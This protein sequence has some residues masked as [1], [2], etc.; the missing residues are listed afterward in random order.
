[1]LPG[2][3]TLQSGRTRSKAAA[4]ARHQVTAAARHGEGRVADPLHEREYQGVRAFIFSCT[5]ALSPARQKAGRGP[6][7]RELPDRRWVAKG[8]SWA[9]QQAAAPRTPVRPRRSRAALRA[10]RLLAAPSASGHHGGG[11][12]PA[13]HVNVM[14]GMHA[15]QQCPLTRLREQVP[16]A[17]ARRSLQVD[18]PS[19][20]ARQ[21]SCQARLQRQRRVRQGA[22]C[23]GSRCQVRSQLA[24]G[25]GQG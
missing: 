19:H 22:S 15:H 14:C 12:S 24:L 11:S 9:N 5:G 18:A 7:T 1:M 25:R 20:A 17:H 21:P 23:R 8:P 16:T 6:L 4:A 3:L 13:A 2:W 10:R